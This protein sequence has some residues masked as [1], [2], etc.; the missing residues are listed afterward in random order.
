MTR[1]S[2]RL[3]QDNENMLRMEEVAADVVYRRPS[4]NLK[5]TIRASSETGD[6]SRMKDLSAGDAGARAKVGRLY[7]SA[8]QLEAFGGATEYRD[9]AEIDGEVWSVV[10]T[11]SEDS[12]L[13]EI[14]IERDVRPVFK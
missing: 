4:A 7:T 12:G 11:L 3:R 8:A 1:F 13:L 10:K 2:D 5:K 14:L 6:L 9:T